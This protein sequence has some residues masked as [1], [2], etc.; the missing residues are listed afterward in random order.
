MDLVRQA[1]GQ[2]GKDY[3]LSIFGPYV[4]VYIF[5]KGITDKRLAN[6]FS[7][8]VEHETILT[9]YH[10]YLEEYQQKHGVALESHPKVIKYGTSLEEFARQQEME[11][12]A[13][14]PPELDVSKLTKRHHHSP[15]HWL[16]THGFWRRK[17]EDCKTE[18]KSQIMTQSSAPPVC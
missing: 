15:L 5:P 2:G 17:S 1:F 7:Q 10:Q 4:A 8:V 3:Q 18:H 16:R 6:F 11:R 13:Q 14:K 12:A 9:L